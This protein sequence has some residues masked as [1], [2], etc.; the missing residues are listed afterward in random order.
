[1]TLENNRILNEKSKVLNDL[2]HFQRQRIIESNRNRYTIAAI[3][4]KIKRD[5]ASVTF[6][7]NEYKDKIAE[8]KNKR[9]VNQHYYD[10]DLEL[11]FSNKPNIP[12]DIDDRWYYYKAYH[13]LKL[14]LFLNKKKAPLFKVKID[15][16]SSDIIYELSQ[17][18]SKDR[19]FVLKQ[20]VSRIFEDINFDL[21]HNSVSANLEIILVK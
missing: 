15:H 9:S 13:Y 5:L 14:G 2:L 1:M 17:L 16:L 18:G 4:E 3:S 6:D 21:Y 8:H 20:A 12:L 19:K 11:D 7:I 10:Y